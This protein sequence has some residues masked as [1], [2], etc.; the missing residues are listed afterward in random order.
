MFLAS[1]ES[2]AIAA[3][4]ALQPRRSGGDVVSPTKA[5]RPQCVCARGGSRSG[6]RF[7]IPSTL[8][9]HIFTLLDRVFLTPKAASKASFQRVSRQKL[10]HHRLRPSSDTSC[11]IAR[12]SARNQNHGRGRDRPRRSNWASRSWGP[13]L[14]PLVYS[15]DCRTR[16][17]SGS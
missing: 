1:P 10:A 12:T 15:S 2:P 11:H 13:C 5:P 9:R 16:L 3:L 17:S 8:A 14:L 4:R 7:F 6:F